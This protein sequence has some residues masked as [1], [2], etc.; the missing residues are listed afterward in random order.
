MIKLAVAGA[1][2]RMGKSII[3]ASQN[4]SQVKLSLAFEQEGT[5]TVGSDAGEVAG[6]GRLDIP[7]SGGLSDTDF[8]VLIEFTNPQ[9]TLE[10]VEKCRGAGKRLVI[11]TTGFSQRQKEEISLAAKDICVVMAPNM[12]MGVNLCFHL[13]DIAARTLKGEVDV[14]IVEAHHRHKMDA[15]SG[16]ALRLGEVAATAV[17]R[18]LDGYAIYGRQGQTGPRDRKT[19]GF[20]TIRGG[21]IVGEHTVL[22]AGEGERVEITHRSSSRM[23]FANGALRAAV[24]SMQHDHGLYDMQDVLGLK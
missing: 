21:D 6:I 4:N 5:A 10:H 1:A 20:S 3:Q 2:G 12:S 8:D 9:A 7:I 11:G 14:E 22:F 23:T 17:G 19:I 13:V 18:D 16:T 24:W 15:P